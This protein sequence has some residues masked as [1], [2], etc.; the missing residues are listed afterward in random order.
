MW[1]LLSYV[2]DITPA[3]TIVLLSIAILGVTM[4]LK[5]AGLIN[6][7]KLMIKPKIK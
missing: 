7:S 1:I 3:G 2:F 6:R 5:S 4:G